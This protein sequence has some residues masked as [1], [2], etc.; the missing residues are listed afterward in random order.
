MFEYGQIIEYI[1]A[2]FDENFNSARKW[3]RENN[4]TFDELIDECKEVEVEKTRTIETYEEQEQI[5]PA[6]Y[7]E[8]G[9]LIKEET[10]EIIQV[11]VT[12][13]ETY[14]EIELHRF[15]KINE[16]PAP[17][18]P[19]PTLEELK[20]AKREEI[21][22][23]R[24]AAEQGGFEYM[25]KIFDSDQVSCQRISTAAQAMSLMPAS[26][27]NKIT[28]TC[29]DNSTIELTAAELSGLVIALAAW[30]NT[31]HQKATALK[32]QIEAAKTTEELE[33]ITWDDNPSTL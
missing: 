9:N 12:K 13:E 19:E 27:E 30:S 32:A 26:D 10:T 33:K 3:C 24:D 18:I 14:T 29:Q 2:T 6:E 17:V 16:I 8:E 4:A 15:F 5:V 28:W 7:D 23:A 31:C 11:P 21:N 1:D 22:Q 20:L 25:G